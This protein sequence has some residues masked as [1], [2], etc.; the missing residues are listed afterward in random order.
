MHEAS[1]HRFNCFLTLSYRDDE[2]AVSLNYTDFQLF[3]KRL[4]ARFPSHDSDVFFVVENT[5]K[6]TRLLVLEMAVSIGLIFMLSYL[7]LISLIGF[8]AEC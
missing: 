2:R 8:L 7:I 4:R 3:M 1:L 6:R 5:V